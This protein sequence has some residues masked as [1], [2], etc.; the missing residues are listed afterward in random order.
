MPEDGRTLVVE[1]KGAGRWT[2]D[3]S[4]EKKKAGE[5]WAEGSNGRCLFL[6]PRGKDWNAIQAAANPSP[7]HHG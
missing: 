1:Y 7:H 5:P 3:D 4:R 6:M 2:D